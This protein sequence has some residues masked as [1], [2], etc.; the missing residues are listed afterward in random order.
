MSSVVRL[1]SRSS[2]GQRQT[3]GAK[4]A[5]RAPTMVKLGNHFGQSQATA[6]KVIRKVNKPC[7]KGE[8]DVRWQWITCFWDERD[9]S[10]KE[11]LRFQRRKADLIDTEKHGRLLKV[12]GNCACH[13]VLESYAVQIWGLLWCFYSD[14]LSQKQITPIQA[15]QFDNSSFL[16]ASFSTRALGT[17]LYNILAQKMVEYSPESDRSFLH[18]ESAYFTQLSLCFDNSDDVFDI[19]VFDELGK[20]LS[21]M[22]AHVAESFF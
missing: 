3:S 16:H 14:G 19:M 18:I 12:L 20:N 7:N 15:F 2:S 6:R 9:Y 10:H 11:E 22:Y 17:V 1:S 13:V 5:S 4:N 21:W 8:K